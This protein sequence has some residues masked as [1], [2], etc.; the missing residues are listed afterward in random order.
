[1]NNNLPP[2]CT[3]RDIDRHFGELSYC[4]LCHKEVYK[5]ELNNEERICKQCQIAIAREDRKD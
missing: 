5:D 2:G 3:P 1:M 4:S